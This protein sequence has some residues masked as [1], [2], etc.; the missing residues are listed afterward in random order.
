MFMTKNPYLVNVYGRILSTADGEKYIYD[1]EENEEALETAETDIK[2]F[3]DKMDS[4]FLDKSKYFAKAYGMT[5]KF[6]GHEIFMND[7]YPIAE[8]CLKTYGYDEAA[9]AC[10]RVVTGL[11]GVS[12][13][14]LRNEFPDEIVDA[15]MILARRNDHSYEFIT[16]IKENDLAKHVRMVELLHRIKTTQ[17]E[18]DLELMIIAG[19]AKEIASLIDWK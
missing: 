12:E 10:L 2:A 5:I 17:A 4:V 7:I 11:S 19:Y 13:F 9:V 14:V 8:E 18:G 3:F 1:R 6:L 15:A 16:A